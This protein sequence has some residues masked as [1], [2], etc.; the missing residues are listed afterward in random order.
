MKINKYEFLLVNNLYS[1]SATIVM[2]LNIKP[3][4]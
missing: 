2:V 1:I 3:D 4:S